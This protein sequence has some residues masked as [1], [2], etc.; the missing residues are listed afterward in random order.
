MQFIFVKLNKQ[1]WCPISLQVAE[2]NCLRIFQI[3]VREDEQIF[4]N[5]Y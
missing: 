3:S 2:V 5:A 1:S 4:R